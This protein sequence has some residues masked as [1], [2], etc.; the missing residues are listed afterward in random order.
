MALKRATDRHSWWLLVTAAV[1]VLLF[2]Y[3]GP[4]LTP[5]LLG[6]LLAYICNPLVHRLERY[7]VPHLLAV[8]LVLLL[9]VG[10]FVALIGVMIPLLESQIALLIERLPDYVENLRSKIEPWLLQH[11]GIALQLD[12]E[13]LSAAVS[14][15]W[16]SAG[17]FAQR[18]LPS[19]KTGGLA[20]INF[21]VNLVLVPVVLFY[22]LR[23]WD[24]L[25]RRVDE[26]VPL[27]WRDT[28]HML[29]RQIDDL[30]GAFFRGQL[31]IMVLMAIF[32]ILTLWAIGLDLA[33]PIGVISGL[34]TFVPF[35]GVF[36][37]VALATLAG[38]MQFGSFMD[39]LPIWGIF[40]IAQPLEGYVFTPWLVGDK[41]GLH[42]VMVIFAV[43][44]FGAIFGFFG[45]LL[46]LPASAVLLV[47]LRYFRRRY[48]ASRI[49]NE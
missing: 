43:L 33:F 5:F 25:L 47:L 38:L 4:V 28:V 45:V 35:L 6:A 44:A 49:Y 27:R 30:L 3:L 23:D 48:F 19:L 10:I 26:L 2:Y 42:P 16:R 24:S 37:G 18:M 32:Y 9:V 22:V 31:S 36:T 40:I 29:A 34:L 39:L 20:L 17:G 15:H 13:H 41:I 12:K 14:E 46:A 7:R 21:F 11:F 1:V 8:I